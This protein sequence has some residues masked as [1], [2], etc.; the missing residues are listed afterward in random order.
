MDFKATT[1]TNFA[2]ALTPRYTIAFVG[3]LPI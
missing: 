1:R 2:E 3:R